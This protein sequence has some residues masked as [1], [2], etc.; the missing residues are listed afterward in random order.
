MSTVAA[1]G[2]K[3]APSAGPADDPSATE[4]YSLAG[5]AEFSLKDNVGAGELLDTVGEP[6]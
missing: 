6:T 4:D 2:S 3:L 5:T 1:L